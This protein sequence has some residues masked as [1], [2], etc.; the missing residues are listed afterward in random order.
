M[1]KQAMLIWTCR[2]S[3]LDSSHRARPNQRTK[4]VKT[5]LQTSGDTQM[6]MVR[7]WMGRNHESI[8]TGDMM[9]IDYLIL[10]F[11]LCACREE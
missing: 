5:K 2:R 7:F 10:S 4:E 11:N 9:K 1:N 8:E 3:S 6:A